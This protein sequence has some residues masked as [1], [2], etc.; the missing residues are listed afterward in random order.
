MLTTEALYQL[1]LEHPRIQTDSRKVGSGDFFFALKGERF[2]GNQ[3]ISDAFKKGCACAVTD[4]PSCAKGHGVYYVENVLRSLQDLARFHRRRLGIPVLA[5]T[6]TNGKT[7]TKELLKKI[8]GSYFYVGATEGNL[9]NHIGVP[10]TL[11]TFSEMTEIGVVEMGA[12]HPGEILELCRIA[13]PTHGIITNVGRAHLE[14]FGSFEGVMQ[15]KKELYD[16]INQHAGAIFINTSNAFLCKMAENFT[17]RM[18]TYGEEDCFFHGVSALSSDPFLVLDYKGILVETRLAGLYN[19]E[20]VSAAC[21]AGMYFGVPDDCIVRS[22]EDYQPENQRSQ[23]VDTGK[24]KLLC[25]LYNANPTSMRAAMTNFM[26]MKSSPKLMILGDML[27]LGLYTEK[28]HRE[29]VLLAEAAQD[30]EV[31][32]VGSHFLSAVSK[33]NCHKTFENIG[34]LQKFLIAHPLKGYH[35]LIKGSRGI[36][37]ENLIPSL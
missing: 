2:D 25:D 11:L 16:W 1:F 29:I 37:L 19:T 28:E 21:C 14:G 32:W 26:H 5:L 27:E 12:N 10:L 23:W 17:S 9:N 3:F 30:I 4:D 22:I 15:T 8:L 31:Y 6:G 7:T 13:E 20:N 24:N 18:I 34:V 35:I 36:H 33:T